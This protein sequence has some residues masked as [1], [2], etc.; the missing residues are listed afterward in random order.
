MVWYEKKRVPKAIATHHSTLNVKNQ[1]K[2]I[3]DKIR[4][5]AEEG[6]VPMQVAYNGMEIVLRREIK[7]DPQ[8]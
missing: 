3:R 8:E 5:F 6:G 4:K 2:A 7:S 1:E